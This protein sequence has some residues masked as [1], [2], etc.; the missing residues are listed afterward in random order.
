MTDDLHV[1]LYRGQD[2]GWHFRFVAANG[3]ELTRSSEG[4]KSKADAMHAA[5][6]A[7]GNLVRIDVEDE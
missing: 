7:H 5:R 4:Y 3:E 2:G 6:L 1:E